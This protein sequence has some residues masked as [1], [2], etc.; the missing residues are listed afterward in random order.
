MC[1]FSHIIYI[2]MSY[3]Y[4]YIYYMCHMHVSSRFHLF[5]SFVAGCHS[6]SYPPAS[7]GSVGRLSLAQPLGGSVLREAPVLGRHSHGPCASPG[8]RGSRS[9]HGP[10]PLV[11][12]IAGMDFHHF[13]PTQRFNR[14]KIS[15]GKTEKCP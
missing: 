2:Y 14:S 15:K 3:L 8:S 5:G 6:A 11:T 10:R 1:D 4:I 13:S 7:V 12:Q 9:V